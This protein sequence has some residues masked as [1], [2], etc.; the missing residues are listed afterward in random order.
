MA[1]FIGNESDSQLWDHP[2]A[3]TDGWQFFADR[4]Q[5][6]LVEKMSRMRTCGGLS[7]CPLK[8]RAS[9]FQHGAVIEGLDWQ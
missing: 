1:F 5:N 6:P 2:R 9:G 4:L 8:Y 7:W 3:P